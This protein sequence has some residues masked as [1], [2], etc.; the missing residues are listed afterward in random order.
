VPP[1]RLGSRELDTNLEPASPLPVDPTVSHPVIRAPAISRSNS[2]T[3]IVVD[4][5]TTSQQAGAS[6]DPLGVG[7][8]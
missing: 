5:P 3:K 4:S 7:L 6:S 2:S 8:S 1:E